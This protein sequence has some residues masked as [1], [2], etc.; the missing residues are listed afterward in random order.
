MALA[1]LSA[2]ACWPGCAHAETPDR[3]GPTSPPGA[4]AIDGVVAVE[5][6]DP[7]YGHAGCLRRA[8]GTVW[9]WTGPGILG[10]FG[11]G[12]TEPTPGPWK[13]E[14][15]TDAIA[16]AAVGKGHCAVRTNGTALCW[17]GPNQRSLTIKQVTA[18][19]GGSEY[20]CALLRDRTVVCSGKNHNGELG[21]PPRRGGEYRFTTESTWAPVPGADNIIHLTT[22]CGVRGDGALYCWGAHALRPTHGPNNVDQFLNAVA[23]RRVAGIPKVARAAVGE[24]LA[25]LVTPRG[26]VEC[27]ARTAADTPPVRRTLAIAAA[28]D[29][30][31]GLG[32]VVLLTRDGQVH[33]WGPG[34]VPATVDGVEWGRRTAEAFGSSHPR[35]VP[36][37]RDI[38]SISATGSHVCGV[39][40][41]GRAQCW[42]RNEVGQLGNGALAEPTAATYVV[43]FDPTLMSGPGE[44]AFGCRASRQIRRTCKQLVPQSPAGC[45]LE[46]PPGY[47]NWGGRGGARCG[48]ECMQRSMQEVHSRAIP[49]CLCTCTDEYKRLQAQE[50]V[51]QSQPPRP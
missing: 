36:G 33:Y 46:P 49:A 3:A 27:F 10:H 48:A 50:W 12:R 5:V 11:R 40:R 14:T 44:Q 32:G 23:P 15:L 31:F 35:P 13:V 6:G 4:D 7:I 20:L 41:A 25:C 19:V 37:M 30:R 29:V 43:D 1:V 18:V 16:L 47:W 51:K 26:R 2:V 38:T 28:V 21:R 39:T 34:P 45:A 9:C 8:D 24:Q 17:S 42:G 22:L